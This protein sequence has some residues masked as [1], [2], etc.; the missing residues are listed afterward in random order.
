M[1]RSTACPPG[2]RSPLFV[3]L[4]VAVVLISYG[5][6]LAVV[7]VMDACFYGRH[8]LPGPGAGTGWARSLF[9]LSRSL[10]LRRGPVP[11]A[12]RCCC[13]AR[14]MRA[15]RCARPCP[16]SRARPPGAMGSWVVVGAGGGLCSPSSPARPSGTPS[17]SRA[18]GRAR[19][20]RRP[21]LPAPPPAAGAARTQ[22]RGPRAR[23]G[24]AAAG[25]D[26]AAPRR[27][28]RRGLALLVDSLCAMTLASAIALVVARVVPDRGRGGQHHPG[29]RGGIRLACPLRAAAGRPDSREAGS[30]AQG[31]GCRGL[32]RCPRSRWCATWPAPSTGC[33]CSTG[34]G[35]RRP[36]STPAATHRR[37][38]R[39]HP[40]HPG[41]ARGRGR[42]GGGARAGLQQPR[43]P[44]HPPPPAQAAAPGRAGFRPRPRPA[45]V[46]S[47]S[48]RALRPHGGGPRPACAR[49]SRSMIH[50]CPRKG[51]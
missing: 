14:T 40:G 48:G 43:R 45:R 38:P 11:R 47:R 19:L 39:G 23:G 28:G 37:P 49:S 34:W 29:L 13:P 24:D 33:R 4:S 27:P 32:P 3:M 9:P 17:R 12:G 41:S 46:P 2:L 18:R 25:R 21:P 22:K 7:A 26:P 20:A 36:P 8:V 10:R 16:T 51:W 50:G 44:A 6:V 42:G 30:R 35:R 5:V 15:R 31:G 1:F